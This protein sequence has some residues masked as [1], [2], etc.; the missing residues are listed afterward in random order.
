MTLLESQGRI[1]SRKDDRR[2]RIKDETIKKRVVVTQII[3]KMI[4][5]RYFGLNMERKQ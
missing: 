4:E 1:H 2:D 5:N 3:E